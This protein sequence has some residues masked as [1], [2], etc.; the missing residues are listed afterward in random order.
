MPGTL[1]V[2][3]NARFAPLELGS[4]QRVTIVVAGHPGRTYSIQW[5]PDLDLWSDFA[6]VTTDGTGLGTY[7]EPSDPPPGNRYFRILWP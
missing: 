6:S 1:T 7:V 3:A 5:S 4:G 2:E